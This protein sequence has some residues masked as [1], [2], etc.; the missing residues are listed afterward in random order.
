MRDGDSRLRESPS[1]ARLASQVAVKEAFYS[2]PHLV[3]QHMAGARFDVVAEVRFSMHRLIRA[4]DGLNS[5]PN[6]FDRTA[7]VE[8]AEVEV[9]RARGDQGCDIGG[10]AVLMQAGDKVG[11]AVQHFVLMNRFV[12][13]QAA[14]AA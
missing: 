9:Q 11:K 3:A 8:F 12:S 14:V 6:F 4:F 2:P 1:H 5:L 7:A 10:V 13:W